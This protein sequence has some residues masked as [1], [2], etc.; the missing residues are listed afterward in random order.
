M[1]K[2]LREA[3]FHRATFFDL[4]FNVRDFLQNF[5][6]RVL[7]FNDWFLY[8]ENFSV[9]WVKH[10]KLLSGKWMGDFET[11]VKGIVNSF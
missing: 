11:N 7:V 2:I 6:L 5:F 3:N 8:D 1:Q 10:R 9:E 4:T